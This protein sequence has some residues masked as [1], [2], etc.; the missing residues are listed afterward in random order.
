MKLKQLAAA[1]AIAMCAAWP[2]SATVITLDFEG[3]GDQ[4]SVGDFYADLGIVFSD[5][6]LA[7]VDFEAGGTGNFANEPSGDTVMFFL[8]ATSAIL[9]F[10]TGF[11]TSFSFFYTSSVAAVVSVWDGLDGTGTQLAE[12][13]L[14]ENG[15][16][17]LGDPY[18]DFATWNEGVVLFEGTARSIN[19]GGAADKTGF[20][21]LSFGTDKPDGPSP[22]P[23]PAA[24]PLL[25]GALVGL[26]SLARRRTRV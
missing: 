26:G 10:A 22:V 12:I 20:D 23:L 13:A 8:D 19:F 18:G 24:A 25:L 16:S 21:N 3:I 6:T 14:L 2:A 4:S 9:N 15:L 1:W 11:Q 17:G 5:Q 7:L